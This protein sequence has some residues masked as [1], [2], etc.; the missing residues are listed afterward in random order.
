MGR[1]IDRSGRERGGGSPEREPPHRVVGGGSQPTGVVVSEELGL[2]GGHVDVDGTV[3]LASLAGEAQVEGVAHR[4]GAPSVG[5]RAAACATVEHLEQEA[6][7]TAGGV[8]LLAGGH[9]RRTHDAATFAT[10]L[11]DTDAA[12][13][14]AVEVAVV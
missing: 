8:L 2:V 7:P 3:R 1:P 11:P 14:G 5:H 10:A 9:V 13:D 6:G 12:K 4:L